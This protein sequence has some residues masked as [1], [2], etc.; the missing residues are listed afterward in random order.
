MNK[1]DETRIEDITHDLDQA[2]GRLLSARLSL[3]GLPPGELPAHGA[4]DAALRDESYQVAKERAHRA[5]RPI[6]EKANDTQA[7]MRAEEAVNELNVRAAE[8]GW[9]LAFFVG[10]NRA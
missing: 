8:L 4:L 6:I 2:L 9:R 7:A 1:L 3:T 10:A 5:W